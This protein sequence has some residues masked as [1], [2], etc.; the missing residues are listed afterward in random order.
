MYYA[1]EAGLLQDKAKAA[2]LFSKSCSQGIKQYCHK[3]G[4][5]YY[6][7]EGGLSQDKAIAK[8]HFTRA[9]RKGFPLSCFKLGMMYSKGDGISRNDETAVY[10]L[11][12]ALRYDPKLL[13]AREELT[14]L[15]VS[16][17]PLN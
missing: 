17:P 3:I 12:E 4:E 13:Q 11:Q 2:R 9:C 5:M 8:D 6:I 10:F 14:R 15:G 1:G 16:L 7:G